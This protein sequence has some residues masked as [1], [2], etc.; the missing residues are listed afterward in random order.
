MVKKTIEIINLMDEKGNSSEPQALGIPCIFH[1]EK[2]IK[3]LTANRQDAVY[4]AQMDM[5]YDLS[6]FWLKHESNWGEQTFIKLI[7]PSDTTEEF[8]RY[9]I[10][11]GI[12]KEYIFPNETRN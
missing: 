5:R 11:K 4:I 3:H 2:Q 6:Q 1:P 10:E 9:L 12:N 8:D 7:L